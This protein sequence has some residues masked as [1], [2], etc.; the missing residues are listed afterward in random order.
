MT[1]CRLIVLTRVDHMDD[2]QITIGKWR[3]RKTIRE[4]IKK[5]Q[6]TF[7]LNMNDTW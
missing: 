1:T 6:E 3:T 2:C 7:E 4:T 5:D